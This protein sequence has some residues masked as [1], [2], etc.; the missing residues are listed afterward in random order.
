MVEASFYRSL[1][2]M[3]SVYAQHNLNYEAVIVQVMK[4]CPIFQQDLVLSCLMAGRTPTCGCRLLSGRLEVVL[5]EY[6]EPLVASHCSTCL[7]CAGENKI[8]KLLYS[9]LIIFKGKNV[10][11]VLL[12]F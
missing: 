9:I 3:W 10:V 2:T 12:T 4:K 11:A 7:C 1:S 6:K 8:E 5:P